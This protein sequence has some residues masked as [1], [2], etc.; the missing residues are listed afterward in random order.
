MRGTTVQNHPPA[1]GIVVTTFMSH[2]TTGGP[3]KK[4][5]ADK[6]PPTGRIQKGQKETPDTAYPSSL[7][8][9][10]SLESVLA[11]GC[12]PPGRALRVI[13]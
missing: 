2:L 13:G 4:R 8:G 9:P 12:M 7:P 10:F 11:E 5:R 6:L 3:G 1:P